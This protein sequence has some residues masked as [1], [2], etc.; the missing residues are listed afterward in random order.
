M[1][2]ITQVQLSSLCPS[3][4]LVCTE[5]VI[6]CHKLSRIIDAPGSTKALM[7][8]DGLIDSVDN[9]VLS[10]LTNMSVLA[11]SNNAISSIMQNA[12][13]NLTFLTTLSLDHN[14][15]SSQTLDNST[16]SWLHRLETLQLGNNNLKDIDGSWFQNSRALKTLQL[17]GNHFTV[18]NSSTFARADLRNLETLDLSDNLIVYIGS[19]SFRGMPSLHSLD[20]SQNHLRNAPDAFSYLSWLSVL[21]LDLN[22]WSCTCELRELA[23]FLNSYIQA[24]DKVLY[25]GQRMVC[26]NT[27]NPAVQTVLELT[28]ANCVPPN[29]NITVEVVA[30]NNNTSQ[31][32][33]RNVA[34]AIV[35]SFFGGVGI[36][37][38]LIAI[39]YHKLSKKFKLVEEQGR[40]GERNTSSPESTQW[41]FCEG[42]DTLSM[43][44]ALYNSN[45]KSHQP[46]KREDSPYLGS[47]ALENHFTCHK[48]S[49]AA[50]AIGKHKREIVLHGANHVSEQLANR[51]HKGND[52]HSVLQQRS[53]DTSGR[54]HNARRSGVSNSHLGSQDTSSQRRGGSKDISA[55][56][57]RQLALS[58]HFS[59]LQ[60]G[61]FRP[62][63][64]IH[65]E[66]TQGNHSLLK[67][68]AEDI[69]S[70]PI[71]Q[72]ISCLHCHQTY[73]Y[74]QAGSNKQNF[75]FTNHSQ[76]TGEQMYDTMLYR[77]ILG[78]DKS[79][80]GRRDESQASELGFK[81]ASQRSVTFD[82]AGPEERVL[83]IMTDRHKKE[84]WMK[85]SKTSAQKSPR[86][87]GK[88]KSST[89]GQLKTHKPRGQAKRTLKVK[90]NL[91]PL[92]KNR[93][94]PKSIDK[95]NNEEDK[96]SKKAK[97]EKV[98]KK[99][100]K[101]VQRKD[102]TSKKSKDNTEGSGNVEEETSETKHAKKG[103][104]DSKSTSK[105]TDEVTK[106]RGQE[107]QS[108]I[109]VEGETLL[110][111][112]FSSRSEAQMA[113][114]LPLTLSL[115]LP[116]EHNS[117]TAQSNPGVLNATDSQQ[118]SDPNI[119]L[120]VS[121][122]AASQDAV[123]QSNSSDP[124]SSPAPVIQE[125]VSLAEGS[126]KRKLRLIIPEKTSNRPQTALDKKIR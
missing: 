113:S 48:C 17:E 33:I 80:A 68:Q 106:E 11:L 13:Q 39:A 45:Y 7:L 26:V 84:S 50:L 53:K 23:S 75:P 36:T 94:H 83:T 18:L 52:Q 79:N 95:D 71:Y 76:N 35:F 54:R 89:Q 25:N 46:W 126:P 29:R 34:I 104:K 122:S 108:Y 10:D 37:L 57:I 27:D 60:R 30:K 66:V 91:N 31:Q 77:D 67:H 56:R 125:Y 115:T 90:L 109:P 118:L 61:T 49:S 65:N 78:Y 21:N 110:E 64:Q 2:T 112:V 22:L 86:K 8:T 14:L 16:F 96:M 51:Q 120:P 121:E 97:K 85:S 116:D 99:D 93:V 103:N 101:D 28:D 41:N 92:R 38:G 81:L 119:A 123:D 19:D 74:R 24:P 69:G 44:H 43:S 124:M 58:N 42:K 73:E 87:L 117:L 72:T 5:D 100:K 63:D 3:S 59:A 82:L 105:D 9:M 98:S 114:T 4:C 1:L 12:F 70:R 107:Q 15:I 47:D 20:L 40:A 6:I 62:P 55:V 32:Y 111:T 102:K 88:T